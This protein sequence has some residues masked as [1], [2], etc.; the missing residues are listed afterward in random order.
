MASELTPAEITVV[1][2]AAKLWDLFCSLHKDGSNEDDAVC[3]QKAIHDIERVIGMRVARRA[4]PDIW[5][6]S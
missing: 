1:A 3:V 2:Q 5:R 4:N 6:Q